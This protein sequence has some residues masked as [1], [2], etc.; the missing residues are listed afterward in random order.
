M[1]YQN[2]NQKI[3]RNPYSLPI[4]DETMEQLDGFQYDTALELKMGYLQD[5]DFS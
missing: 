3:V 2:I 5:T 1:D 4:V